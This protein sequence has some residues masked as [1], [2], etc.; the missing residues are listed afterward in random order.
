VIALIY[1]VI[2]VGARTFAAADP[3]PRPESARKTHAYTTAGPR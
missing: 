1:A 2:L 3:A